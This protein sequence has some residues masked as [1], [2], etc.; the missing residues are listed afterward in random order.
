MRRFP[1]EEKR[2]ADYKYLFALPDTPNKESVSTIT[3]VKAK[4]QR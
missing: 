2:G 1:T 4:P 3:L